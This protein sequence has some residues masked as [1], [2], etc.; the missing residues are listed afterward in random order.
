MAS[1][2]DDAGLVLVLAVEPHTVSVPRVRIWLA[3]EL[4]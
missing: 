4:L 3:S 2:L 1:V